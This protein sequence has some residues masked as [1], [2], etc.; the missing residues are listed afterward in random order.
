MDSDSEQTLFDFFIPI[1]T[2]FEAHFQAL[3]KNRVDNL[4]HI[5][6]SSLL[7]LQ[8]QVATANKYICI[9]IGLN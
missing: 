7:K 1:Y 9:C 3:K 6:Y 8:R 5:F 2:M 4:T